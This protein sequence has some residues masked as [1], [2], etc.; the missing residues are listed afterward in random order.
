MKTFKKKFL[1]TA[2]VSAS[3]LGLAGAAQAVNVNPDGLGQVLIYP[4]YT[5]RDHVEGASFDS[6]FSVVNST[7][8]GKAVKVRFLE[9]K[10]SREV[11]DFNLY[12]SPYDVWTAAISQDADGA[13]LLTGDTSCTRPVNLNSLGKFRNYEYIG[14][15]ADF[16]DTSLDRTREGYAEVIEMASS[17]ADE[18]PTVYFTHRHASW[19][20]GHASLVNNADTGWLPPSGGLFGSMTLIAPKAGLDIAYDPVALDD[21][22]SV[23]A[24]TATG[25]LFPNLNSAEPM[26]VVVNGSYTYYTD[27][28]DIGANGETNGL[29]GATAV[30]AV[31]MHANVMNEFVRK[32][33]ADADTD[34]VITM[35]T[36]RF[37]YDRDARDNVNRLIPV[38]TLFQED[39]GLGGACDDVGF[40]YFDREELGQEAA[41][42]DVSPRPPTSTIGICWE[43]NVITF[44]KPIFGS[45]NA[46]SFNLPDTHLN[47]WGKLS[48]LQGTSGIHELF[49]PVEGAGNGTQTVIYDAY[50]GPVAIPATANVVYSGLPT[51]GFAAQVFNN[52]A[53]D[54][55]SG[56]VNAN[57]A[58]RLNH[59]MERVITP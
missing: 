14:P 34:W 29:D 33:G 59:K 1:V 13:F 53:L 41:A 2:L 6:L 30:S 51:I 10:N 18:T 32:G 57:Y 12:L 23:K 50:T 26:S 16:E 5:V 4:Y 21:F 37:F 39:F 43:A 40:H 17:E 3:A 58:G 35:P 27:W 49:T 28:D 47:G 31:L 44:N 25:S 22:R 36:K 45:T 54:G 56:K 7:G 42:E 38:I 46:M 15:N 20:C 8:D 9:G 19:N 55:P 48:F 11:L 52:G 24:I